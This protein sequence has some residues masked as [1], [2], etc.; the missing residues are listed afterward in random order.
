M[1]EHSYEDEVI[2]PYCDYKYE[3]GSWEFDSGEA[4]CESCNKT[5]QLELDHSVSY[6]TKRI[7]C[8]KHSW[9]PNEIPFI[10][11][12]NDWVGGKTIGMEESKWKYHEIYSCK[13][14]DDK[15]YKEITKEEYKE[16]YSEE[17]ARQRES[18]LKHIGIE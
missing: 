12:N 9:I 17:Y 11:C 18:A 14:C 16:K 5:F 15:D 1:T 3:D 4:T 8:K 7:D 13:N 10:I 6:S 2:C